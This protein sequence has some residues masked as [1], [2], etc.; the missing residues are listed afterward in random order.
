MEP[1]LQITLL[2]LSAF[3]GAA[4]GFIFSRLAEVL[5]R[6]YERVNLHYSALV[7][8]ENLCN[9]QMDS[10]NRVK[11]EITSMISSYENAREAGVIPMFMNRPHPV[12]F[13]E[14]ILI[15]LA[16]LDLVNEIFA[17]KLS[18]IRINSDIEKVNIFSDDL[19]TALLQKTIGENQYLE[20]L[21]NLV[22]KFSE[23]KAHIDLRFGKTVK[24]CSM[25]RIR[26]R[27]EKPLFNRAIDAIRRTRREKGF[28]EMV[29]KEEKKLLQE[30]MEIGNQSQEEINTVKQ[31]EQD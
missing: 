30:I 31:M 10:L 21:K 13:D 5:K 18:I 29:L 6:Y 26:L 4:I 8:L 19:K 24:L 25:V 7:R 2:M 12:P 16:N 23:L 17:H 15:Q 22:P 28:E 20:N 27:K 1:S 3:S 14:S 9:E 11:F